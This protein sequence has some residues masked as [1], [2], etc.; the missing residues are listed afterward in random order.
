MASYYL[1]IP[2]K[3]LL[4]KMCKSSD[5]IVLQYMSSHKFLCKTICSFKQLSSITMKVF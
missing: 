2:S 5:F 3:H 4:F 1:K